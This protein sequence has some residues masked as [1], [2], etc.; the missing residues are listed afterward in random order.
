MLNHLIHILSP[1]KENVH[2]LFLCFVFHDVINNH[3]Q[4]KT[5]LLINGGDIFSV[6]KLYDLAVACYIYSM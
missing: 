5:Y 6:N 1:S 4:E 3:T 2:G